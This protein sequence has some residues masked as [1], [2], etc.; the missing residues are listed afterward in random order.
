MALT[1]EL[2]VSEWPTARVIGSVT[3]IHQTFL[4]I[5]KFAYCIYIIM[6]EWVESLNIFVNDKKTHN[7]KSHFANVTGPQL[8]LFNETSICNKLSEFT[9]QEMEQFKI[10][11]QKLKKNESKLQAFLSEFNELKGSIVDSLIGIK[12]GQFSNITSVNN[13]I[14]YCYQLG[15]ELYDINEYFEYIST[16]RISKFEIILSSSIVNIIPKL[17]NI[18]VKYPIDSY[19]EHILFFMDNFMSFHFNVIG[20]NDWIQSGFL[21]A[22][23]HKLQ[24]KSEVL[25]N[26]CSVLSC[27]AE[28]A[29]HVSTNES[30]KQEFYKKN[31]ITILYAYIKNCALKTVRNDLDNRFHLKDDKNVNRAHLLFPFRII[32]FVSESNQN[33]QCKWIINNTYALKWLLKE[34]DYALRNKIFASHKYGFRLSVAVWN[35]SISIN[36]LYD[37]KNWHLKQLLLNENICNIVWYLG[38]SLAY[39]E[40]QLHFRQILYDNVCECLYKISIDSNNINLLF[41]YQF[42]CL[43]RENRK[44]KREQDKIDSCN[45]DTSEDDEMDENAEVLDDNV[46][47]SLNWIMQNKCKFKRASKF[48][49]LIQQNIQNH[50]IN[51]FEKYSLLSCFSND[52][53]FEIVSCIW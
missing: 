29:V 1:A 43:F 36:K 13:M 52:V 45:E 2:L 12:S 8:L 40:S 3:N 14:Y 32:L 47:S 31:V 24:D 26:K 33:K 19:G 16:E 9:E 35:R 22:L 4:K 30:L 25:S 18:F 15:A 6:S 20:V 48:A 44:I 39:N 42:Q 7:W 38:R 41:K 28:M 21:N 53:L 51:I 49:I 27:L 23:L 50:Y 10:K 5:L 11:L 17:S 34:Y 37:N 46:W